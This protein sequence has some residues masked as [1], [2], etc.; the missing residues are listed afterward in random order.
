MP[1][2]DPEVP[3]VPQTPRCAQAPTSAPAAIQFFGPENAL[4]APAAAAPTA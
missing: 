3:V 1:E 4:I 2:A